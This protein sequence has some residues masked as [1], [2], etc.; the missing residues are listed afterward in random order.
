MTSNRNEFGEPITDEMIRCHS[1]G[2]LLALVVTR[3]WLILCY[4][5]KAQNR[6]GSYQGSP[7]AEVLSR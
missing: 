6:G 4:R 7:P 3:P 1:C 2:K 5:C